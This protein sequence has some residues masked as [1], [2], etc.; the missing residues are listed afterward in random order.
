M[1]NISVNV[2]ET[3]QSIL[4][5]VV[6]DIVRQLIEI[7]HI[8][9]S[10]AILF[11][12]DFGK[13]HQQGSALSEHEREKTKFPTSDRVTIEV[14]EDYDPTS[15]LSTA[16][17]R[18][19]HLP[20]FD[21][22]E[23]GV[24]VKPIYSKQNVEITFKYRG[25]S[26]TEVMKWRDDIRMRTSMGREMNLHKASYHY[27]IPREIIHILREIHRLREK[28]AGYADGDFY[29]YLMDKATPRFTEISNQAGTIVEP[30]IAETQMRIVGLFD[31][32]FAPAKMENEEEGGNGW[33]CTFVY[34]FSFDKPI[35]CNMRYPCMIHNQVLSP[36]YR[37]TD[38][39]YD[40]DEHNQTFSLSM[41]AFN[42]F[43]AQLQLGKRVNLVAAMTL[44]EF[45][46]FIPDTVPYGT[47]PI[48]TALCAIT[49]TDKK[50]LLD[51][52]ELGNAVID[53][54]IMTFIRESEQPFM[55]KA[56]KSIFQLLLY[57][58][59]N[60]ASFDA[61]TFGEDMVVQSPI[62]LSLRTSHRV[63]LAI[64][65]DLSLLDTAALARLKR[66]P[67]ALIKITKAIDEAI[68]NN[69]AIARIQTTDVA[70]I[71]NFNTVQTQQV[72]AYRS[73]K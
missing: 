39:A 42:Y 38:K 8:P 69:P 33:I 5:P 63:R 3:K 52:N 30:A 43:E 1:P 14:N 55:T 62:D 65:A 61:I 40:I 29:K 71:I 34:K 15:I 26:K 46:E 24:F 60:L 23:I 72:H 37:P 36:K 68:R 6:L 51:L 25:A 67:G 17:A 70:N 54:E 50:T 27:V 18:P 19:E 45:D 12:D 13:V 59:M 49:A 44:P 66:Y 35:A 41:A 57:R 11:P 21:D 47:A 4:R 9:T 31:F 16:I 28:Q 7:T 22:E 10:S 56:Y 58:S 2:I 53:S 64:V 48:F 20:I 32:E 73:N